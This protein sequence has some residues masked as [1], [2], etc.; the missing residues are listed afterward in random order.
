[1][2]IF[3]MARQLAKEI[4]KDE[5]YIALEKTK[6][7]NSEDKE[8]QT[9]IIKFNDKRN[10]INSLAVMPERDEEAIDKLNEEMRAIYNEVISHPTMVAFNDAKDEMESLIAIVNRIIVGAANGQDPDLISTDPSSC[11]SDCSTC[12]GCH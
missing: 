11:T 7:A 3:E 8:L 2:D 9:L 10:E 12:G 4:Q 1:M 5:R 6:K